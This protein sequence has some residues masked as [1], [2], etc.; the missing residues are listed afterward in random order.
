MN[1]MNQTE[2]KREAIPNG[3]SRVVFTVLSVLLQVLWIV[4]AAIKLT[5]SAYR[6][7]QAVF[8]RRV[9]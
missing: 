4:W 6:K 2:E 9:V 1:P 8:L 7:R 5:R 3:V